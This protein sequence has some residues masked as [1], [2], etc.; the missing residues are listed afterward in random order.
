[1][2]DL[3]ALQ[4]RCIATLDRHQRIAL[5]VSGGKDS[6]AVLY[7]LRD[8]MH[9]VTAY[10]MDTGDL[11]PE[12]A[13][14]IEH[15]KAMCPNFVHIR[16]DVMAWHRE[17][18]LPSDMVADYRNRDGIH[19]PRPGLRMVP[20][21]DCCFANLML[22]L[23]QRM[24]ADGNTLV[25]RGTK[26]VDLPRL[27]VVDGQTVAGAEFLYPI[28]DWSH[29]AVFAY[30]RSVGAPIGRIYEHV[31]N[32]PECARCPAWLGEKRAAYLTEYHPA[33]AADYRTRL[34]AVWREI[35]P[36]LVTLAEVMALEGP[37]PR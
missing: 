36:A 33:L 17:H 30:L 16:G 5:G 28:Q 32:A 11:L 24:M 13:E 2:I 6:L 15:V 12:V 20:R 21:Y 19:P 22:P 31:A 23:W 14:T 4:A 26:T 18:G 8:Q 9:R 10:H 1:M 27:P 37:T 34:H 25:I 29:E 35:D 7:L 3:D